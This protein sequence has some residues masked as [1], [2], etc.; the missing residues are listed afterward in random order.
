[1]RRIFWVFATLS[2]M[3]SSAAFAQLT[4]SDNILYFEKDEKYKTLHVRNLSHYKTFNVKSLALEV[5]S[6]GDPKGELK[7]VKNLFTAP[8]HFNIEPRSEV[9]IKIFFQRE[10]SMPMQGVYRLRFIP[11]IEPYAAKEGEPYIAVVTGAGA[12]IFVEPDKKAPKLSWEREGNVITI[13]NEGN[14]NVEVLRRDICHSKKEDLCHF[15]SG[16]RLYPN[17]SYQ[18]VLPEEFQTEEIEIHLMTNLKKQR[19]MVPVETWGLDS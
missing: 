12:L 2:W 6:P 16:K 15:I 14:V 4:L 18:F 3:L 1:M 17:G 13:L 9:P 5:V 19:V 7:E 11:H 10:E 8:G